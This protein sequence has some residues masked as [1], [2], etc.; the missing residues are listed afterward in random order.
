MN[1]VSQFRPFFPTFYDLTFRQI[2]D[3][4]NE[5]FKNETKNI[6]SIINNQQK[7]GE[8]SQEDIFNYRR[9]VT[10]IINFSIKIYYFI[11]NQIIKNYIDTDA[12][13]IYAYIY[14]N[15]HETS[16]R[17]RPY[18]YEQVLN[19]INEISIKH[20]DILLRNSK[21]QDSPSSISLDYDLSIKYRN[22]TIFLTGCLNFDHVYIITKEDQNIS[23]HKIKNFFTKKYY[24]ISFFDLFIPIFD[25]LD[26]TEGLERKKLIELIV[27]IIKKSNSK[28]VLNFF[29]K[30]T[31]PMNPGFYAEFYN[32]Y[33]IRYERIPKI[34]MIVDD[35]LNNNFN[36]DESKIEMT[37]V[38][39]NWS[40]NNLQKYMK[41]IALFTFNNITDYEVEYLP[42][43][44]H[45][46]ILIP[47]YFIFIIL[48][49]EEN[50]D[51]F[52]ELESES[53]NMFTD[54]IEQ[55]SL[56][57]IDIDEFK[58]KIDDDFQSA[59]I[60][61]KNGIRDNLGSL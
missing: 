61:C 7:I 29:K 33:Q 30:F 26:G 51:F 27:L 36:I 5:I 60:Y 4:F 59:V 39:Y 44:D 2:Q 53:L 11:I 48:T 37:P 9:Y 58:R 12:L 24:S 18:I 42:P 47:L 23:I 43:D 21:I 10:N 46:L 40:M 45:C 3:Q 20:I 13:P 25:I 56:A 31:Y 50:E 55:S 49:K 54:F 22:F 14:N 15:F 8:S 17:Y 57:G 1:F 32:E 34:E 41:S 28:K 19:Y 35:I 38:F 6:E 52:N 16:F